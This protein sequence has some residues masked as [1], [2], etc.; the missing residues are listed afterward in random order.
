MQLHT[1]AK[2]FHVIAM[3][4]SKS[5]SSSSSSKSSDGP[6]Q[7]LKQIKKQAGN[8]AADVRDGVI[9]AKDEVK[10][11]IGD[12]A[13]SVMRTIREEAE[14]LFEDRRGS[15]ASRVSKFGKVVHQAAHALHAVKMDGVAGYI[16]AAADQAKRASNYIKERKLK[17]IT[18]DASRL[19]SRHRG[20]IVG[21]L[22]ITGLALARFL[23]ASAEDSQDGQSRGDDREDED[24]D[25]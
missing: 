11:E 6:V 4:R 21:G 12:A 14:E 20:L 25:S 24:D 22:F 3:R 10:K 15:V 9:A 19:V 8:I 7:V 1:R 18:Q 17:D 23:K 16:D 5:S 2:E 13:E